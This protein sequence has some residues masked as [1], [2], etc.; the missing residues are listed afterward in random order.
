MKN[1]LT[2]H[3]QHDENLVLVQIFING[4]LLRCNKFLN[5]QVFFAWL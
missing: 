3:F 5:R 1:E 4:K 2:G